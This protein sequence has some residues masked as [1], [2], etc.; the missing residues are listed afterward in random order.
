[1]ELKEGF[2]PYKLLQP[3]ET[4]GSFL[5]FSVAIWFGCGNNW[6]YVVQ[7]HGFGEKYI[8]Y[9]SEI[10]GISLEESFSPI[11]GKDTVPRSH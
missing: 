11:L 1:M 4:I 10:K 5:F 6:L 2:H 7:H 9:N 3:K 8:H